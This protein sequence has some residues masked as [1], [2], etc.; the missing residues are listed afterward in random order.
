[1][2]FAKK[3][4]PYS[5][6]TKIKEPSSSTLRSTGFAIQDLLK[7]AKTKGFIKEIYRVPVPALVKNPRPDF[8]KD[9][10]TKLTPF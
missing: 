4:T 10:W 3:N 1:M 6:L 7:Y 2:S 8:T 9:E 5:Y